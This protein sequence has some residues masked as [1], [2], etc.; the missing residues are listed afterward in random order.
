MA[1]IEAFE[2]LMLKGKKFFIIILYALCMVINAHAQNINECI[3]SLLKHSN[4]LLS[5][6]NYKQVLDSSKVVFEL[7][8]TKRLNKSKTQAYNNMAICYKELGKYDKADYYYQQSISLATGK[9]KDRYLYHYTNYLLLIGSYQKAIDCLNLIESSDYKFQKT[10]NLSSAYFRQGDIDKSLS[11][12]DEYLNTNDSTD[13]NYPTAIQNKGFI[14]WDIE[15]Y[16]SAKTYLKKALSF[17]PDTQKGYYVTLANLAV[18]QSELN[19]S[20]EALR[21]INRVIRWQAVN[22]GTSHPDYIVSLRKK[23]EILLKVK[24]KTKEVFQTFQEYYEKEKE[25]IIN[26]FPK[27]EEEHRLSYWY[28]N[29]PL[30]SEIFQLEDLNPSYL[31]DVALFRRQM[32]LLRKDADD[33]RRETSVDVTMLQKA[34]K[35]SEVAIEFVCYYD[36][37][38]KD[39][40]YAAL[41]TSHDGTTKYIHIATKKEL[42]NY[43]LKDGSQ[44]EE[45]VCTSGANVK[46]VIYTDSVLAEKIWSH[47]FAAMPLK[48]TK[49]YFAPD[50]ILQMLGIENLPYKGLEGKEVHRLT[51]TANL[52]YR[53]TDRT[54]TMKNRRALVIGGVDY[55]VVSGESE[56]S[57]EE[58]HLAY[59]Y[60][61]DECGINVS[62]GLFPY[63]QG[64]KTEADSII[65]KLAQVDDGKAGRSSEG[66]LKK[67]LADYGLVHLST[68]GYSL[69]VNIGKLSVSQSD[70][71]KIDNALLASGIVLQ[72]ANVA[73]LD[74]E[75]EDGLLSARE[76]CDVESLEGVDLVVL[77]ACQTAQGVVADE[78]PTGIVRGLKKAGAKTVMAS[79]WPVNDD[80][81][82]LF[83]ESFY[84]A[85]LKPGITKYDAL[86]EAQDSVKNYTIPIAPMRF[87]PKTLSYR[88]ITE[89]RS[90]RTEFK[91]Y[92]EP[93]YWAPFI[94]IDDI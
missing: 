13:T 9:D 25:F 62:K 42:H 67:H 46:S 40:I 17:I 14:Y 49:I 21:N 73:G 10:L 59:N 19:D 60:M 12:L 86:R 61:K 15:Q 72:G 63:L 76:L 28:A 41:L 57:V 3:D 29:K 54:F 45:G 35:E 16:D 39:T 81:T 11:F 5:Q 83:M 77:S 6:G 84:N 82:A 47:I 34:I 43:K 7:I 23:A 20:V 48:T 24:G 70:S 30:I 80:A 64:S 79:L 94:L 65:R 85:L 87:S 90:E 71:L 27:E 69:K 22:I 18:V 2:V 32:A 92:K 51:S 36:N 68:H 58:N 31:Y 37:A 53:K 78:G 33:I 44:L 91:P 56:D 74:G 88:P 26:K 50:G 1:E 55:D 89:D 52:L 8:G 66:Y 93:Y 38:A 4:C 75:K